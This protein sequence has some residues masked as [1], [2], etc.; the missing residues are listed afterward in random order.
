MTKM[1]SEL[2]SIVFIIMLYCDLVKLPTLAFKMIN[3]DSPGSAFVGDSI[4][5]SC[6]YTLGPDSVASPNVPSIMRHSREPSIGVTGS[7]LPS[8][9]QL[10]TSESLYAIK[11][12]KDEAEFFR[13]LAHDM[14]RKL[15]LA[16]AGIQVDVSNG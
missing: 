16:V 12:Y 8:T 1:I 5:L 13:F 10:A 3:L 9:G 14:P 4:K 15:A 2:S 6:L 7:T 11:W